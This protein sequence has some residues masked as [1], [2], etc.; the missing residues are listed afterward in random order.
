MSEKLLTLIRS[1]GKL[2][3]LSQKAEAQKTGRNCR[4]TKKKDCVNLAFLPKKQ[5]GKKEKIDS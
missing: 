3:K 2:T 1:Y 4:L 5:E